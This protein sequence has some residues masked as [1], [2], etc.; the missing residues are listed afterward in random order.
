MIESMILVS[1]TLV[2]SEMDPSVLEPPD[3]CSSKTGS[4][5]DPKASNIGLLI[6]D[7][8][9]ILLGTWKRA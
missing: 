9:Q 6:Q 4:L 1:G 5:E 2:T 8:A 3:G 7:S